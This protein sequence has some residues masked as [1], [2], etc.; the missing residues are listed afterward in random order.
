[1]YPKT[2]ITFVCL[3]KDE[4]R[5]SSSGIENLTK[6]SDKVDNKVN[7]FLLE[8]VNKVIEK[9]ISK[10]KVKARAYKVL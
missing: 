6:F 8:V 10:P 7:K 3:Y 4:G 1:M 9:K 5:Q 2:I